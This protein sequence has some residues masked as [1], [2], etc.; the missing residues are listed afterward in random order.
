MRCYI[1][2]ILS[3]LE[4]HLNEARGLLANDDSQSNNNYF[5]NFAVMILHWGNSM[6]NQQAKCICVSDFHETW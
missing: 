4:A 3:R 6:S 1:Q 5:V 2:P